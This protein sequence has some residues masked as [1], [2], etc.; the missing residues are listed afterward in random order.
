MEGAPFDP[1]GA[2]AIDVAE[3]IVVTS[4]IEEEIHEARLEI[5]D[6]EERLVVTVLEVISPTNKVA[7]SGS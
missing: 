7:G 4:L 2:D 6:R 5:I 1:A 3:P